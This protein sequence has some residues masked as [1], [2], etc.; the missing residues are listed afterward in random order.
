VPSVAI[1]RRAV[2]S[3]RWQVQLMLRTAIMVGAA[4]GVPKV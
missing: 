2:G 4:K 1:L 3:A